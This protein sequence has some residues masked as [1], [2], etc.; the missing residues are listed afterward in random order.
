MTLPPMANKVNLSPFYTNVTRVIL[1]V[2]ESVIKRP[3]PLFVLKGTYD[4]SCY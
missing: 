1:A 2:G 3:S 4:H